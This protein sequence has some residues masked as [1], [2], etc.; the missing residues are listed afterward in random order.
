MNNIY[1]KFLMSGSNSNSVAGA[2]AAAAA[3]AAA[4][5]NTAVGK[6]QVPPAVT[7]PRCTEDLLGG[8]Y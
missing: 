6:G 2:N 4:G 3:V 7:P 1:S 5:S 8:E